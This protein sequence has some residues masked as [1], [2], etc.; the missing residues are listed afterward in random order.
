MLL[1][2]WLAPK[3]GKMNKSLAMIGYPSGITCC[4]LQEKIL[5]SY[6]KSPFLTKFVCQGYC[7]G[8]GSIGSLSLRL[9]DNLSAFEVGIPVD[10]I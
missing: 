2:I 3:V 5:E 4:V 7:R 9:N 6:T 8:N 1:I 10:L